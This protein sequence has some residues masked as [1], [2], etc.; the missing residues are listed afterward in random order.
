M[1]LLYLLVLPAGADISPLVIAVEQQDDPLPVEVDEDAEQDVRRGGR[2]RRPESEY[3][4]RIVEASWR[5]RNR[6]S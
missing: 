5:T 1:R 2:R 3:R 4:A 6:A